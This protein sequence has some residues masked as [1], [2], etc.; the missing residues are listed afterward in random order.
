MDADAQLD[1]VVG[2][3]EV[4]RPAAG[5]VHEVRANPMERAASAVR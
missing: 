4:G 3:I 1:L 2:K 5:T